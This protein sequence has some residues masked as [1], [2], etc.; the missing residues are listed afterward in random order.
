MTQS[1]KTPHGSKTL[2]TEIHSDYFIS[3]AVL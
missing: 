2:D 3:E 1:C